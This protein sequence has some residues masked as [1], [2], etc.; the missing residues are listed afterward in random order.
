MYI[1]IAFTKSN[2]LNVCLTFDRIHENDYYTRLYKI[3][4]SA[5]FRR[6]NS[7]WWLILFDSLFDYLTTIYIVSSSLNSTNFRYQQLI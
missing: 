5:T 3:H 7:N 6:M 1:L 4:L 2:I